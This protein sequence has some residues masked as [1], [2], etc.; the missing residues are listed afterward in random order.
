MYDISPRGDLTNGVL[1]NNESLKGHRSE[2]KGICFE[3]L[4]S[5]MMKKFTNIYRSNDENDVHKFS[6]AYVT[7]T[8][9]QTMVNI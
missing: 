9:F 2:R 7:N 8:P 1:G 5:T 3:P 4:I 6:L